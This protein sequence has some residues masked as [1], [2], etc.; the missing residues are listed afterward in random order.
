MSFSNAA[1]RRAQ[2]RF[3]LSRRD[4]LRFSAASVLGA[5]VPWF[6]RLQAYAAEQTAPGKKPPKQCIVLWMG[7]G[8]SQAHTFDVK[9]TDQVKTIKTSVP[10]I[11]ISE[12]LPQLAQQMQNLTLLRTMSHGNFD[13]EGAQWLMSTGFK[14]NEGGLTYPGLGA[15]ISGLRGPS[16]NELPDN[17]SIDTGALGKMRD[18]AGYL[19]PQF[20]PLR[21]VPGQAIPDLQSITETSAE[22]RVSRLKALQEINQSFIQHNHA[23]VPG[24]HEVAFSQALRLM[25]TTKTKAFELDEESATTQE[26]YG[27]GG[28]GRGCLLA[29]RLIETGVPFVSVN[30]RSSVNN[31][32]WDTHQNTPQRIK[33]L[34]AEMDPAFAMLLKDLKERGLLDSTLVLW[35]GDFGRSRNGV[36]HNNKLW[37]AA[38][39]GAGLKT[40]LAIGD[41]GE[42]G[43]TIAAGRKISPADL[44]ATALKALELDPTH[45][46]TA[47]GDRPVPAVNKSARIIEEL[48]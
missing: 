5:S 46:F 14:K 31:A 8:A 15:I 21:V 13:H 45:E 23:G 3:G 39:A 48:F 47:R 19:G 4:L 16:S 2:A 33:E 6:D 43:K 36:E 12:Y 32:D 7:G 10:D 1:I 37:T 27:K 26:A 44:F 18:G 35:I 17:I 40:G 29:R 42:T 22:Q 41:T 11:Q 30:M 34:C 25:Q 9:P 24:G 20:N 28:F 38:I